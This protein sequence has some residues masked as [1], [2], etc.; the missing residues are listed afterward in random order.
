MTTNRPKMAVKR[1]M[2]SP[3]ASQCSGAKKSSTWSGMSVLKLGNARAGDDVGLHD[4]VLEAGVLEEPAP[5]RCQR[6]A[7]P[8]HP[9]HPLRFRVGGQAFKQPL[10]GLLG[11]GE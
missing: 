8:V 4:V 11:V 1:I 10:L 5:F 9:D 2:S 3:R 6:G 7:D